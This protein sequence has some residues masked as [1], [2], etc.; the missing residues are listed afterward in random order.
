MTVDTS[1]L[2]KSP[3]VSYDYNKKK[4]SLCVTVELPG[5]EP[6]TY[7]LKMATCAASMKCSAQYQR[8]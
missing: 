3:E 5:V 7:V 6:G 2:I 1:K 4:E 8:V